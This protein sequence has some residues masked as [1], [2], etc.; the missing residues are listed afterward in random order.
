MMREAEEGGEGPGSEDGEEGTAS[1]AEGEEGEE[2]GFAGLDEDTV[3]AIRRAQRRAERAL[4]RGDFGAARRFQDEATEELRDLSGAVA[5]ELDRMRGDKAREDYD[6]DERDP[7][8]N[9]VGGLDDTDA[10]EIPEE[11][12]RQRAKDILD[13]IRRRFGEAEDDD[14]RDYLERLLDRF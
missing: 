11:A 4:E 7:F 6:G 1:G 9:P 13:E 2:G 5:E 8:G 14:E 3:E 12:E 10:I